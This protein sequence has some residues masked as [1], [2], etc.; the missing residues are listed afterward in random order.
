MTV[1]ILVFLLA[2]IWRRGSYDESVAPP[3]TAI[4]SDLNTE[5]NLPTPRL[6]TAPIPRQSTLAEVQQELLNP[7]HDGW[8]TESFAALAQDR[9]EDLVDFTK[10]L[11][12]RA[13]IGAT[14]F[15]SNS[16]RPQPLK[17]TF[18][19]KIFVVRQ[20]KEMHSPLY[21]QTPIDQA[22]RQFEAPFSQATDRRV[23]VKTIHVDTDGPLRQTTH[24]LEASGTTA[25][26]RLEQHAEWN[27][28]WTA[29]KPPR[30][31]SLASRD[32]EESHCKLANATLMS[33]ATENVL[34]HT[35][36]F[37]K[38]LQFGLNHWLQRIET[39]HGM[40]VFAEY[41]LSLGDVNGDGHDDLYVCQPGGLPNRLLV[42]QTNGRM[43]DMTHE[44]NTG[45]LEQCSSSLF[46]DLDND[47]DQDLA[48]ALE[49]RQIIVMQ[50]NGTGLF[51]TA[52]QLELSD[53]HVQSLSAVDFD[54]DGKL[55]LY[56]TLGFANAPDR[57]RPQPFVYHDA[58][59][60]GRN[61]LFRNMIRGDDWSFEDVTT[62]VGLDENNHRHSLAVSWE[63]YDNDGDQ[64]L[65][66]ANDYGQN[67]LYRNDNGR[68][69]EI[70]EQAGVI[71]FGSGMSVSWSDY[72]N[73]GNID[74]Y[75]GNMFSAAGNRIS[76]QPAFQPQATPETRKILSRFAKGNTLFKNLGNGLFS[77]VEMAGGAELGRWAWSSVLCDLTNDG[78]DDIVVANGYITTDDNQDL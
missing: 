39:H 58:N 31:H 22:I 72:D 64:D 60:G 23:A 47:G 41:G 43:K 67:C 9:I 35:S 68:F 15:R 32:Y 18:E 8:A 55:D 12:T 75:V 66:V 30:L 25:T 70:A 52:A 16:L 74:L 6:D 61:L 40:Y 57:D 54:N 21:Q 27:C 37:N 42:R 45:W 14:S 73:D 77:D 69:V 5:A 38:Q 19:D 50:N 1:G 3:E 65:Y 7:D 13:A 63:D 46:V 2:A 53:R 48:V 20:A 24:I 26:G 71:D 59:D 10:P 17:T 76:R 78:R 34:G 56:I 29:D 49:S 11:Q 44:S 4:S 51:E 62:R 36:V 33:D 28:E